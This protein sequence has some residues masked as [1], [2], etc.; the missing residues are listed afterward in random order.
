MEKDN[1]E[2]D[3][4]YAPDN[5]PAGKANNVKGMAAR[6]LKELCRQKWKLLSAFVCV[7][8]GSAFTLAAPLIIGQAINLIY[9]GIISGRAFEVNVST[10]GS[11]ML[12]LLTLY[13][14]SAV[15]FYLQE[16]TLAGV[17][18]QLTLSLREK[19]SEKLTRLPLRY[20]DQHKKGDI[21]SR[22]TN[23]LDKV[24]STLDD[25][26]QQFFGAAVS[27]LG[28][29]ILMLVISP[30]LTFIALA[31]VI[32]SM[33]AAAWIAQ[34]TQRYYAETQ[35]ALGE[36]NG[37]IEEAFT[38][39]HV[40][41]AFNL[42]QDS[43]RNVE[44][45]NQVLYNAN[46]KAQFITYAVDPVI[47][48]CNNIGYIF[49][50]VQGA[51]LVTQGRITIGSIQ[52]F[53]QY[54]NQA[55]EPLTQIAH[56]VNS[57]QGAIAA[58]ERV[59]VFLD[60]EEEA[61]DP[62]NPL[63]IAS[64]RG[65]ISFEH[66]RFGYQDDVVLMNDISFRVKAGDKIALVGPTGAGKTTLINLLMR[67]YELQGGKITIDGVNITEMSRSHLR[68]LLGMVLQDA[69][70]FGGTIEQNIAYGREAATQEEI[71]QAAKAAGA[72]HFIRT[73]PAG[74]QT[75]LDDEATAISQGERQLLTIARAILADPAILILDE[76]TSN[77]DTRTELEIQKAMAALMKG[78]TSFI[79]AHRLST[80]RDADHILVM[81]NGTII[82]Q[83]THTELLKQ[84]SFYAD[85]Y[86]SQ[87]TTTR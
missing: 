15:F 47:R 39:N 76:A 82:E 41:K 30:L 71:I 75:I 37:T 72:D 21:L 63:E 69:W 57:M 18:Q 12:T 36:M 84:N 50:A 70:L 64:P 29:F 87:F 45:L 25:G 4:C 7:L 58:A 74:Y 67:F 2:N 43:I 9:E 38:G 81:K 51:L 23:D 86:N 6:L 59:F 3:V 54:V 24:A 80:I 33:A 40:I 5:L 85:L 31:T 35:K 53:F 11:I 1:L 27:I 17:A 62:P 20:Y 56:I 77:V 8:F 26:L 79:I 10:L 44:A 13:L 55:S 42:E 60:E 16:L 65:N 48:I 78:R 61:V 68:S 66:V 19:V 52:A 28:S 46:K 49:I 32:G 22:A 14:F 73:L 34:R 83:G